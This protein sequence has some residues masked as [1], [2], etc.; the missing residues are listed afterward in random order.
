MLKCDGLVS[1]PRCCA[2]TGVASPGKRRRARN[3]ADEALA[4][5]ISRSSKL[6]A[7]KVLQPFSQI[8]YSTGS[9]SRLFM[10]F[11]TNSPFEGGEPPEGRQ[12]SN[13]TDSNNLTASI[14][15]V[16]CTRA[17]RNHTLESGHGCARSRF[18]RSA[19][20]SFQPVRILL[21]PPVRLRPPAWSRPG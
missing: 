1:V 6:L 4:F 13:A 7:A 8:F 19:R 12:G 2:G 20:G 16:E 5:V 15:R 11:S 9:C 21:V 14:P 17:I 18:Q 3:R 10:Y